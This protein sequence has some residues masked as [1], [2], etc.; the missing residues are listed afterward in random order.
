MPLVSSSQERWR[1]REDLFQIFKKTGCLAGPAL[2]QILLYLEAS[3]TT[4]QAYC[5]KYL[6][7]VLRVRGTAADFPACCM[8]GQQPSRDC[9]Q[10]HD[11]NEYKKAPSLYYQQ[12][13][14]MA[15]VSAKIAR[16]HGY[17]LPECRFSHKECPQGALCRS[18]HFP[19]S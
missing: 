15:E 4:V 7:H 14:V 11:Y 10:M 19:S 1:A 16:K 12:T 2:D 9:L 5:R 8:S 6:N 3:D 17:R 13:S 18:T